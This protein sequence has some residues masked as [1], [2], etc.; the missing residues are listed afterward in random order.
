MDLNQSKLTKAEWETIEKPVS[1]REKKILNMIMKGY[2][3][4]NIRHNDTKSFF[5]FTKIEKTPEIE[6]FIFRKYFQNDM[7]KAIDKYAKGTPVSSITEM[8]FM[9]EGNEFKRL[10]SSDSIRIQNAEQNIENNKKKIFEYILIEL[11][12]QL[13]RYY[14][15]KKENYI[16]YLYTI[17]HMKNATIDNIN[18]FV[19]GYID[20]VIQYIGS[21]VFIPDVL[22]MAYDLIE[23]NKYLIKYSDMELYS[24]QKKIFQIYS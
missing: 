8:T 7:H 13:I 3:E 15:K 10:R 6:Y 12:V 21:K 1:E 9:K 2:V 16:F 22:Y 4:N 5:S 14:S 23:Q 19:L 18:K 17:I 24:H 11:F 20:K